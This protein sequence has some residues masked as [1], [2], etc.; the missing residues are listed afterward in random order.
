MDNS[1]IKETPT[2]AEV[3]DIDD[4][5]GAAQD[6][7]PF[8]QKVYFASQFECFVRRCNHSWKKCELR[9][10]TLLPTAVASSI[11]KKILLRTKLFSSFL[12]PGKSLHRSCSC[13]PFVLGW[14]WMV[15]PIVT[16][17]ST[18]SFSVSH[19]D[20][21]CSA[22][23]PFAVFQTAAARTSKHGSVM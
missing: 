8:P 11:S 14:S 3:Y 5:S 6:W 23:L 17:S 16:I 10:L 2:L 1:V 21:Y 7:Y 18:C 19:I 15:C 9:V 13:H 20:M 12:A 22:G 4:P